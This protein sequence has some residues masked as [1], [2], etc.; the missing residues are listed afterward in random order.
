VITHPHVASQIARER[1]REKLAQ[2]GQQRLLRQLRDLAR[3]SRH[4]QQATRPMTRPL[5]RIRRAL[6]PS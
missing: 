6:L 5:L 2:A 3:A 4:P 1:Q